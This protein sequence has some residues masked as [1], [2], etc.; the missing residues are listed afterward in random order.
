MSI[1]ISTPKGDVTIRAATPDDATALYALRL[2]AL[3]LHPEVFAA[4]YTMTAAEGAEAWAE[5]ITEYSSSQSSYISIVLGSEM[6]V[7]MAGLDRGHWPKTRHI[8]A[9]WGV[10]VKPEWRRYSI[11]ERLVK[12]CIDWAKENGIAVVTLGVNITDIPAFRCYSK[13]GLTL[14]GIEPRAIYHQGKY[15]DEILMARV[16]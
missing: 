2:E 14:Y 1:I 13:C 5:K 6:L 9:L 8:G 7:G 11:G 10:Y 4:D 3:S 12:S 15:Y 16:L